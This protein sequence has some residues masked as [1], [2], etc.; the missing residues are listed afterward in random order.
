MLPLFQLSNFNETETAPNAMDIEH[1]ERARQSF[2]LHQ[3]NKTDEMEGLFQHTSLRSVINAAATILCTRSV[4]D[5]AELMMRPYKLLA[6][7][8]SSRSKFLKER[9]FNSN[10]RSIDEPTCASLLTYPNEYESMS[11]CRYNYA[12]DS[13]DV[14][15]AK[16]F[17]EG[18]V[19]R[20]ALERQRRIADS[21]GGK[22]ASKKCSE[23]RYVNEMIALPPNLREKKKEKGRCKSDQI[24]CA[25]RKH[26]TG[27]QNEGESDC[28]NED[29]RLI[30]FLNKRDENNP[31]SLVHKK[32]HQPFLSL[33]KPDLSHYN[34]KGE[35]NVL[36]ITKLTKYMGGIHTA[37]ETDRTLGELLKKR[38]NST[39]RPPLV[40]RARK[41]GRNVFR[42]Y[43][44]ENVMRNKSARP[45][46]SDAQ[47]EMPSSRLWQRCFLPEDYHNEE[48][49]TQRS[50][51][52]AELPID[53]QVH[54]K[55]SF[56][57][58]ETLADAIYSLFLFNAQSNKETVKVSSLKAGEKQADKSA[59]KANYLSKQ[60]PERMNEVDIPKLIHKMKGARNS[61]SYMRLR[62]NDSNL[63]E[64]SD[65]SS[66]RAAKNYELKSLPRWSIPFADLPQKSPTSN[67]NMESPASLSFI[68]AV[69]QQT[70]TVTCEKQ[71][72]REVNKLCSYED[73][74]NSLCTQKYATLFFWYSK[75]V[76]QMPRFLQE[77]FPTYPKVFQ[78]EE[79]MLCYLDVSEAERST[80]PELVLTEIRKVTG[81]CKNFKGVMH[82]RRL[83][84]L[85]PRKISYRHF[86]S[87][88]E[89][90]MLN[91][92]VRF[93]DSANELQKA[94]VKHKVVIEKYNSRISNDLNN[95]S[96]EVEEASIRQTRP[97]IKFTK[98]WYNRCPSMED[99]N[100]INYSDKALRSNASAEHKEFLHLKSK[101]LKRLGLKPG[102]N[103]A[104]FFV[105]T[106]FQGVAT[107][108]CEIYLWNWNDKIVISDID[109][110]I[111]KSDILGH[112]LPLFGNQWIHKGVAKLLSKIREQ[113]Y[114]ILFL[115]SR[116]M[117]QSQMT[118]TY[119]TSINEGETFMPDG[120]LLMAPLTVLAA[121]HQEV[122]MKTP[123][124]F[125]AKCLQE[126]KNLFPNSVMPFHGAFG[127]Q[128]T[129]IYAYAAM[130][131]PP[132][133]IFR[134]NPH[135]FLVSAARYVHYNYEGLTDRVNWLFP[136]L[137]KPQNQV[138][139][140]K[141][142]K[143]R[144]VPLKQLPKE[145][146][147][148][149]HARD[150]NI[151]LRIR[152]I[153]E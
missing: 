85:R 95:Y 55:N 24:E 122:V 34:E 3:K 58:N 87:S 47:T 105:S 140:K 153:L 80:I 64:E 124:V 72:P 81:S 52:V 121:L 120:P 11:E 101:K 62:S 41:G 111:T 2:K 25:N 134:I 14:A 43:Y 83:S 136:N 53:T 75:F 132:E 149:K 45:N 129:D 16:C 17:D 69:N 130:G 4:A 141:L 88:T 143:K 98:I 89:D 38:T 31:V 50:S 30:A 39:S 76:H 91:I 6:S 123:H 139:K 77:T 150:W 145:I 35:R 92:A 32:N 5:K 57:L 106:K 93:I 70:N 21:A 20:N 103:S 66:G 26:H 48:E 33:S 40:I 10:F 68:H 116:P 112:F 46:R 60:Q 56:L 113:G 97:I 127:N 84:S 137:N 73:L 100:L 138:T 146:V 63:R 99:E 109:G 18:F 13:E 74:V 104:K 126:I 142:Q 9:I 44:E 82:G 131:I 79:P 54:D 94:Y 152:H 36:Q 59:H 108:E 115:S 144:K 117:G 71:R 27:V 42:Y 1:L 90:C 110:T 107:C 125:K 51:Y 67:I 102:P 15:R 19:Q 12:V 119:L 78:T 86:F 37:E 22:S 28:S 114:Q 96:K 65:D 135:S 8:N 128:I 23:S 118:K 7:S 29:K 61:P 148:F 133:R 151:Q 49:K 147:I